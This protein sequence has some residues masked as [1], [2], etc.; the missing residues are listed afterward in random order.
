M[1]TVKLTAKELEFGIKALQGYLAN[2]RMEIVDTDSAAYKEALKNEDATLEAV[3]AKLRA[4]AK[5]KGT[6]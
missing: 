2:L 3:L 5:A 1:I 4:L 6:A